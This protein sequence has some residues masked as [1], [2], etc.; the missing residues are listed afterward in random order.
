M[1]NQ[2][3]KCRWE[4]S[5]T[6]TIILEI[7]LKYYEWMNVEEGG[8][9]TYIQYYLFLQKYQSETTSPIQ[10]ISLLKVIF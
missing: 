3:D 10:R 4:H 1:T 5:E 7:A 9:S 6:P 8:H 2:P